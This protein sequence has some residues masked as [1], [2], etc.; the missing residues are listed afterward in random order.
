[1]PGAT[2]APASSTR[3]RRG[4]TDKPIANETAAPGAS[5]PFAAS[6]LSAQARANAKGG[7]SR[8]P[9]AC[10]PTQRAPG[11][12][13]RRARSALCLLQ[14]RALDHPGI[15]VPLAIAALFLGRGEGHAPCWP[16]TLPPVKWGPPVAPRR[17]RGL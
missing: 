10:L 7:A 8:D 16:V 1:M 3:S 11:R 17:N 14:E 5:C 13:A 6:S 15:A 12:I 9:P 4:G 2:F